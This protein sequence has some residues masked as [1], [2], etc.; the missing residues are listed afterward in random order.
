MVEVVD[1]DTIRVDIGGKVYPV[2]YIG[3]DAPETRVPEQ[4][5]EPYGPEASAKNAELVAGETVRLEKDVSE[6]DRYGRLLRYV[7]VGDVMVNAELVRL[8]FARVSTFPPDVK[9][10][11]LFL[12]TE[13]EA[14][15][16]GRGLWGTA[17]P[18]PARGPGA[19]PSST[20]ASSSGYTCDR[21]IKGNINIEGAKI[22]HFPG[23]GEYGKTGIAASRGERWFSSE[24]EAQA[25]GWRKA[26]DCP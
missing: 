9:Y 3:M 6:T 20:A 21:C 24:A 2:R 25:A 16:A 19:A 11:D 14:R 12:R 10:Q 13:R 26:R 7:W 4:P 18:A 15:A 22:Y 17:T 1:G 23:C 8:G 5:A